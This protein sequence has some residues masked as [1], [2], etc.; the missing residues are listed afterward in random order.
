MFVPWCSRCICD[1]ICIC[2]CAATLRRVW[3]TEGLWEVVES[4]AG[5]RFPRLSENIH[6]NLQI[7]ATQWSGW[8]KGDVA[9]FSLFAAFFILNLTVIMMII[10]SMTIKWWY[11][12]NMTMTTRWPSENIC[13]NLQMK[14]SVWSPAGPG[15]HFASLSCPPC[16]LPFLLLYKL[17]PDFLLFLPISSSLVHCVSISLPSPSIRRPTTTA[18]HPFPT[19]SFFLK[20]SE[21]QT[22]KIKQW[23]FL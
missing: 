19:F 4:E 16:T 5:Q 18:C 14:W 6:S 3:F 13:L 20:L 23:R 2:I 15:S 10:A 12:R 8:K 22:W 7:V 21:E 1:W 9:D 17:P 11:W